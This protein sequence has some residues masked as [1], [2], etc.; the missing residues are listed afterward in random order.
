MFASLQDSTQNLED[1][2]VVSGVQTD[3]LTSPKIKDALRYS[4]HVNEIFS[5][6]SMFVFYWFIDVLIFRKDKDD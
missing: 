3:L 2:E 4:V 1:G 5:F 6:I